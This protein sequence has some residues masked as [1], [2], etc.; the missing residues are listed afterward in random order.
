MQRRQGWGEGEAGDGRPGVQPDTRS[1]QRDQAN[2]GHILAGGG[3]RFALIGHRALPR[4]SPAVLS[5]LAGCQVGFNLFLFRFL[6]AS[7]RLPVNRGREVGGPKG[8]ARWE[9]RQNHLSRLF[10]QE[11]S[12]SAGGTT[13][14]VLGPGGCHAVCKVCPTAG[15]G[16]P[17]AAV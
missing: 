17:P 14:A 5:Y 7:L 16:G 13:P 2:H 10:L 11:N 12:V 6:P 15:G 1:S 9:L 3:G 8:G 4:G